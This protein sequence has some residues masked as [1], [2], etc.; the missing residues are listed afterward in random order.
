MN[1]ILQLMPQI[2]IEE[3]VT[4]DVLLKDKSEQQ[5]NNFRILYLNRRKDPQLVLITTAIGLLGL[6][7]I[8]RLI[9]EQPAIGVIYLL[10]FGFCGIGTIV[11]LINHRNLTLEYNQK[12]ARDLMLWI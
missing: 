2:T 4:L 7:G 12:M 3:A 10:T 5:I 8:Q 1:R 11:D 9:L 6:A